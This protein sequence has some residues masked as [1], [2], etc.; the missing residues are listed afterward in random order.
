MLNWR[1]VSTIYNR[2]RNQQWSG[3]VLIMLAMVVVLQTAVVSRDVA[4]GGV[5][6]CDTGKC[7]KG[8]EE[9]GFKK[10]KD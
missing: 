6:I 3:V 5:C 1:S 9:L 7:D 2:L 8:N 10:I 4:A